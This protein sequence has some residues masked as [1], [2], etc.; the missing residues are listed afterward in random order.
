MTAHLLRLPLWAALAA[1]L[2]G[3]AAAG[4]SAAQGAK[5]NSTTPAHTPIIAGLHQTHALL[6]QANHDYDG[7]R[8]KAAH[9]VTKAIHVLDHHK[10]HNPGT[11]RPSNN[12]PPIRED[13]AKS[14]AQL[15][16]AAQQLQTILNQLSSLPTADLRAAE[17]IP[18]VRAAIADI[19]TALQ[20]R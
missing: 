4:P 6:Q 12:Q 5:K 1:L 16:Q 2:F 18:H 11:T 17:A 13:Q 3:A 9:Q 20:I 10:K 7:Y 19:G 14:D 15:R 8:A